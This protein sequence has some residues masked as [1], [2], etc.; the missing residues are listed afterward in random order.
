MGLYYINKAGWK[1]NILPNLANKAVCYCNLANKAV[2]NP[3]AF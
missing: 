3:N 2:C 1:P